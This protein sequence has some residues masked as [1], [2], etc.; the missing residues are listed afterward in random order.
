M[1]ALTTG[2]P[3]SKASYRPSRLFFDRLFLGI[4][5]AYFKVSDNSVGGTVSPKSKHSI[6]VEVPGGISLWYELK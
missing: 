6:K 3:G 5:L 4:L 2:D 1:S